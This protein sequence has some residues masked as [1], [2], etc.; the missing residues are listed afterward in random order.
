M[1]DDEIYASLEARYRVLMERLEV[2]VQRRA[3]LD[4]EER[5]IRAQQALIKEIMRE[6]ESSVTATEGVTASP[7]PE[8][9]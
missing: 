3:A 7:G 8:H 4:A 5:T 9:T 2:L 6:A 1:T